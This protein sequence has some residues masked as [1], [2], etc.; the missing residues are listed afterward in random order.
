MLGARI[1]LARVSPHAPQT[2][3]STISAIRACNRA[4]KELINASRAKRQVKL[5]LQ[6]KLWTRRRPRPDSAKPQGLQ[7][8]L[9][10]PP[11]SPKE[12]WPGL[13]S[14]TVWLK[15]SSLRQPPN[16]FRTPA[17]KKAARGT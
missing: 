1:E 14:V 11:E 2:C 10:K 4:S 5:W 7:W 9:A 3:A 13:T 16:E 12:P 6:E 17:A 15:A 8:P